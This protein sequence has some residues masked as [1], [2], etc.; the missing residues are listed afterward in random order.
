MATLISAAPLPSASIEWVSCSS[1]NPE[2]PPGLECSQ[3]EVPLDWNDACGEKIAL[4]LTRLSSPNSDK[5][6]SLIYNPGGPGSLASEV[7]AAQAL[8]ADASVLTPFSKNLTEKFDIVGVDPRGIG[9]S[10]HIRCDPEAWN[11]RTSYFPKTE[12]EFSQMVENNKAVWKSCEALSGR[13]MGFV[14]TVS[15]AKDLD[16]VKKALG[17]EKLTF[18]GA[19]YGSL[20]GQT[21]AKLYPDGYRALAL[22]GI[23]DH[24]QSETNPVLTEAL[25][26]DQEFVRFADWCSNSTACAGHGMDVLKIWN[27]LVHQANKSPIPAPGCD[28]KACA[29]DIQGEDMLFAAQGA[30]LHVQPLTPGSASWALL[31]VAIAEAAQG[32]ATLFSASIG[33]AQSENDPRF[34]GPAIS[35]LDWPAASLDF[36]AF[37]SKYAEVAAASPNVRAATQSWTIQAQCI[38]YPFKPTN[39]PGDMSVENKHSTP[40]LLVQSRFDPSTSLTWAENV[41]EQIAETRF[42]LREGDGHTSY[43]HGGGA[44][45]VMDD[46]LVNLKLPEDGLSVAT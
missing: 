28:G 11:K 2:A 6:G 9:L 14:D 18:M 16:A 5:I 15:V 12:N 17:D 33:L 23:V 45:K 20:I 3:L 37:Q 24:D 30:L 41:R 19:S 7:L 39:L 43:F 38:G 35:C 42:V 10:T 13:L 31:A 22:D 44:A 21:Y 8:A 29:Q 46:Y 36:K 25:A 1:L 34:A 32:N 40:V 26:Y 27:T 4:G